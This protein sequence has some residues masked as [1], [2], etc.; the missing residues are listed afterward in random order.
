MELIEIYID[1]EKGLEEF[2]SALE[3]DEIF[4]KW[5]K[6]YLFIFILSKSFRFNLLDFF[7]SY[8]IKA[9]ITNLRKPLKITT[10]YKLRENNLW[11]LA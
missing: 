3:Q 4:K 6:P 2:E 11:E 10:Y 7:Q 5:W 8:F 1:L 9:L